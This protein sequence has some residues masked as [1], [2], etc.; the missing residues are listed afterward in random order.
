MTATRPSP[1]GLVSRTRPLAEAGDLLDSLGHDGAAWLHDGGGLVTSG[2]AARIGVGLGPDRFRRAADDV[3]AL[4]DATDTDDPLG[5]PGTGPLAIGALPFHSQARGQLVVPAV[6]VG[7]TAQGVAWVTDTAPV[8]AGPG[9][10]GASAPD[11]APARLS[12]AGDG[13]GLVGDR[14]DDGRRAWTA[15]VHD[16]VARIVSGP[17]AK[18]VLAREVVVDADRAFDRRDILERLR[19]GDLASFTYAV[20]GFIG[21]SPELLVRRRGNRVVSRP[22][23]GTA[24]RGATPADDARMVAALAASP[25]EGEEHA[26]VVRAVREALDPVCAELVAGNRPD[27]VRL[28]TVTHLATTV[29]GRLLEPAPSALALVGLL[30]PTPAVGGLPCADA[31]TAIAELEAFDR[32]LYAGPVGWVDSRGDGDWA[33]AL[34]CARLDGTRARLVAGAGIMAGSDPDAEWAET[35][36]KLEPMLRALQVSARR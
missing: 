28:A 15:A 7:R 2:V 16:A 25:K 29:A 17:L 1:T 35:E 20:G 10:D 26:L 4:L 11:P 36:A 31:L 30:H 18:V 32:G 19:Q 21:A 8:A 13:A 9:G 6:V 33:V 27:S 12:V 5:L 3:A 24:V 34:R 22:M 14:G 23:A